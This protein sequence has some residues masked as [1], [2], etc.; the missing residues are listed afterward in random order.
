M[1]RRTTPEER[2]RYRFLHEVGIC[3]ATGRTGEI[4]VAHL[5]SGAPVFGKVSPGMGAKPAWVWTVPLWAEAHR[6]QHAMGER[7][8]WAARGFDWLD[9][10]RSPLVI[11]AMLELYRALDDAA[12][13]RAWIYARLGW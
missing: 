10:V 4:E 7:Q 6:E 2:A 1:T 9:P 13:A 5:R 8:F 11:A 12:G 3:A